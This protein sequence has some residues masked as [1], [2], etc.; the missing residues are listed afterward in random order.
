[1]TI[2]DARPDDFDAIQELNRQIF[3]YEYD[4]CSNTMNKDYPFIS[5]GVNYF[6]KIVNK[7]DGNY[8]LVFEQDNKVIGYA[9]LR[10]IKYS[11]LQ[12]RTGIQQV[13]LQTLCVDHKHRKQN[14]GHQLVEASKNWAIEQGANNLKVIAMAKNA[15]ARHF[16]QSCGF[17]EYE[18]I[19]EIS[20]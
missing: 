7:L 14:I 19:H 17:K 18:I 13:Q 6:N 11:D 5:E 10:L 2:R 1:M 12:H 15:N 9:S 8:G 16:Y 4:N 3:E 20:L